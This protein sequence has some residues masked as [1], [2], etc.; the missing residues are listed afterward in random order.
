LLLRLSNAEKDKR[1]AENHI[2]YQNSKILMLKDQVGSLTSKLEERN[3]AQAEIQAKTPKGE[4]PT[5]V[6]HKLGGGFDGLDT[7]A[8]KN[9]AHKLGGGPV[10]ESTI[11]EEISCAGREGDASWKVRTPVSTRLGLSPIE[12]GRM[13]RS[14]EGKSMLE[15]SF[16]PSM[17]E[18]SISNFEIDSPEYISRVIKPDPTTELMRRK[19]AYKAYILGGKTTLADNKDELF[20]HWVSE[21]NAA[22]SSLFLQHVFWS[23]KLENG[24]GPINPFASGDHQI[25]QAFHAG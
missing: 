14:L 4:S 15:Y 11:D 12:G 21:V 6:V 10:P 17:Q 23:F 3:S 19:Y 1:I 2:L 5:L 8:P 9:P 20:M 25:S 18:R 7:P 13:K 22:A 24:F 16:S